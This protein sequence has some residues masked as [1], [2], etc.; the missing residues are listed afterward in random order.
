M[1]RIQGSFSPVLLAILD[2]TS[3]VLPL[4]Y[5]HQLLLVHGHASCNAGYGFTYTQ[6]QGFHVLTML[7]PCFFRPQALEIQGK[8]PE[9][10]DELVKICRIHYIFPPE[11][12]SVCRFVLRLKAC[13]LALHLFCIHSIFTP[14]CTLCLDVLVELCG[15][16]IV[17]LDLCRS[18][19]RQY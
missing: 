4:L 2:Q 1:V 14:L 3:F 11:D 17:H 7:I 12:N 9:A 15:F 6:L 16:K 18:I 13:L 10:L 19:T 8:R 5:V